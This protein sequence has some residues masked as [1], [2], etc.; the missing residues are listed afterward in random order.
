MSLV[1][2]NTRVLAADVTGVQRYTAE[3]LCRWDGHV[4][5]VSPDQK[6]QGLAGHAWEQ[7]VLPTKLKGRLL[8]SP[9]GSG[10]LATKNQVVTIHDTAVLDCPQSFSASYG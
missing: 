8:F 4:G 3:L 1:A 9:S 5:R 2:V 7:L 10:P 6:C